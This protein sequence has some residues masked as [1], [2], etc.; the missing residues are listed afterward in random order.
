MTKKGNKSKK[1][2]KEK[3]RN[4]EFNEPLGEFAEPPLTFEKIWQLFMETDR[5]FKETDREFKE[6]DRRFKETDRQFKET[7]RQF[8]ETALQFKETDRRFKETDRRFKETELQ[9][10]ETD[11]KI[12]KLANLFTTQWG[13]LM[14]A[15][16]A[17]SCLQ[18]FKDRNI[19]VN[20]TYSNIKIERE[21]LQGEFDI[22]LANGKEIVIIEVKTTLTVGYVNEF[23]EK[24]HRIREYLPEQKDKLVYGAVAGIKYENNSD[25]Y[26]YR[27]GLFVLVNKGEDLIR[28]ANKEGFTPKEF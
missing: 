6:T 24:L 22:V 4:E 23:L 11:K 12:E 15:L 25:K 14:E 13:K 10:K 21:N 19:D 18:L 2:Y 20:T 27:N 16:I 28:I 17:P 26:A 9:F 8:K 5:K 7:D 1:E 3:T